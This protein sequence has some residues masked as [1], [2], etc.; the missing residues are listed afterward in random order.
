MI[1]WVAPMPTASTRASTHARRDS[2]VVPPG[3]GPRCRTPRGSRPDLVERR[4]SARRAGRRSRRMSDRR[5]VPGH[6]RQQPAVGEPGRQRDAALLLPAEPDPRTARGQRRRVVRRAD[7]AGRTGRRGSRPSGVVAA[8]ETIARIV[9]TAD[10]NRSNRSG[11]GGNGIPNGAC[12]GSNQ[13]APRPRMN[14][15]PVAWSMTVADFASTDGWRNVV[16]QHA[17]PEPLAR[18]VVGERRHRGERLPRGPGAIE[19]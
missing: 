14:R 17:V 9:S 1:T 2:A 13:P 8:A 7:R 11:I 4:A 6:G 15:P 19:R 12:S 16:G 3:T 10:S 18:D 5:L